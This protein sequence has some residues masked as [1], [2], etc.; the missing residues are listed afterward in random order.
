[1]NMSNFGQKLFKPHEPKTRRFS[2]LLHRGAEPF[3]KPS[4]IWSVWNL[5]RKAGK[6]HEDESP[7]P[8]LQDCELKQQGS[9]YAPPRARAGGGQRRN[10]GGSAGWPLVESRVGDSKNFAGRSAA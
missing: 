4:S 8:R 7:A 9:G 10:S 5:R 1:M 3:S 2:A 6:E